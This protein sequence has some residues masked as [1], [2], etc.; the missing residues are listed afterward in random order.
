MT[1]LSSHKFYPNAIRL[2]QKCNLFALGG[3]GAGGGAGG[4][5]GVMNT[6]VDYGISSCSLLLGTT[7]QWP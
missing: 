4:G 2:Y 6:L 1:I 7:P 5:D 3:D